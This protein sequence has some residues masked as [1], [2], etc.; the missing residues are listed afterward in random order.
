MFDGNRQQLL[1]QRYS[2][3]AAALSL[4][5]AELWGGGALS[6][7]YRPGLSEQC[8]WEHICIQKATH[9]AVALKCAVQKDQ[10]ETK[11]GGA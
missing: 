7:S 11:I 1:A 3:E 9:E 4:E 10:K 8:E 5:G 6:V 2:E